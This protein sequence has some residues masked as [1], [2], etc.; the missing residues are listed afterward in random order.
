L[1]SVGEEK[2]F[3]FSLNKRT[4]ENQK[5]KNKIKEPVGSNEATVLGFPFQSNSMLS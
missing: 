4:G 2:S 3:S 1:L 5:Q